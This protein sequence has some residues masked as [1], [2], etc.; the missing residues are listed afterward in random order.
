MK[1]IKRKILKKKR[2]KIINSIKK[3]TPAIIFKAKNMVVTLRNKTQ[4]K[5]WIEKYP[6]GTFVIN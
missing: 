3:S 5:Y 1:K 2:D 4:L 6:E